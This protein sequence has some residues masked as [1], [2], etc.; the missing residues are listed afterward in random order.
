MSHDSELPSASIATLKRRAQLLQRLRQFFDEAGYWEVET[1]LL[2][3]DTCVDLWLE[4]F[5]VSV[6]AMTCFLQTSP[7]FAMKRLLCAGADAIYEVTRSFRRGEQGAKHN[8]EFTI[9]EWYRVGDTHLEQ[10]AFTERLVRDLWT[11]SYDQGWHQ[12]KP[13]I[14]QFERWTYQQAFLEFA[15]IDP[16]TASDA[17]LR[18]LAESIS[19]APHTNSQRDELLN[20]ILAEQ[21]EPQI[22]KRPALFL[23]DYPASQ[24]A[25]AKISSQDPRTAER[26]E[27]YLY[28]S[29]ICNGYHELTNARE[30]RERMERQQKLRA[31]HGLRALCSDSR[32]LEAMEKHG[33]PD[34]S[35]V[36]LGFD[37][38][39]IF[40]TLAS[41]VCD[42]IAFPF[43]RA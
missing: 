39:F 38:L 35:G 5:D 33:L 17:E 43:D 20:V 21:I 13:F 1:P 15:G 11:W 40:C 30:L 6:G 41:S 22:A 23:Y 4:P 24:A 25:L 29:E 7:E 10:M 2:S 27:L 16:L 26:F 36:A 12:H 19:N 42:V 8:P 37:R 28:G 14:Q 3:R 32:L 34:C 18:N 31:E 9:A